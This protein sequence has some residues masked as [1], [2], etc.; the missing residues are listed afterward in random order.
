[1]TGNL[2]INGAMTWDNGYIL[3]DTLTTGIDDTLTIAVGAALEMNTGSKKNAD[4]IAIVN[5]GAF[6]WTAGNF[7]LTYLTSTRESYF[8]NNSIVNITMTTDRNLLGGEFTIF[9]N[10]GTINFSNTAASPITQFSLFFNDQGTVNVNA[11]T[12]DVRVGGVFTKPPIILPVVQSSGSGVPVS[13]WT[14]L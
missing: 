12:L 13:Q 2:T 1:M 10:L 5:N 11:G 14:A 6:N 8:L 7:D 9:E 4:N 3:G